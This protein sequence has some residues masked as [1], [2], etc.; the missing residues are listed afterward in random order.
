RELA[1][2]ALRVSPLRAHAAGDYPK[3]DDHADAAVRAAMT[4]GHTDVV[5][6]APLTTM[7]TALR[8]AGP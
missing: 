1:D 7:L 2:I 8:L 5:S 4:A 3:L 6:D